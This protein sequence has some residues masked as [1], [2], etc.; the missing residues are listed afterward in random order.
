MISHRTAS[1]ALTL[2]V[3][4]PAA[5]QAQTPPRPARAAA[6]ASPPAP[7]PTPAPTPAAAPPVPAAPQQ[8]TASFADWTLR[9]NRVGP[10]PGT[11]FCEIGQGIQRD[12]R[13]VAQM[14]IGRPTKDQPMRLTVLVPNNVSFAAPVLLAPPREGDGASLE[15]PWRRCLPGGCTADAPLND[16]ALRRMRGWTEP[17]R[18]VFP[19][20]AGRPTAL[21]FSPRGLP[22][23]LDALMKE[24]GN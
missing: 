4:L 13:P 1:L 8:T 18:V 24:E 11:Q 20:A 7:A 5:G 14:A 6:A 15:L 22:Q 2:L 19:D 16:E 12:D 9:C 10:A 17:A 23:A 21:P 3:L